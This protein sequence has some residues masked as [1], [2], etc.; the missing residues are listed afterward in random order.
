MRKDRNIVDLTFVIQPCKFHS[1][2]GWNVR[3]KNV[4]SNYFLTLFGNFLVSYQH[5]WNVTVGNINSTA[6][7]VSWLPL[8]TS[9]LKS[10]D[11]YGYVVVYLPRGSSDILLLSVENA[12]SSNT[13]VR[14]LKSY[15][16]YKVKVV[17]LLKDRVTGVITLKSSE[18]ADIRTKE[19]G[20]SLLLF[21]TY[22][23]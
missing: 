20:T 5:S 11:I 9:S 14:N 13:V 19:G 3:S 7:N 4:W 1:A 8:H 15:K 10:S 12:S 18:K 17:A 21:V 23:L 22:F 6:V 2:E 16:K